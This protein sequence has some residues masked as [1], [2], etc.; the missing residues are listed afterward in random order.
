MAHELTSTDHMVSGSNVT[1]WHGL[2]TV[3]PGQLTAV[4][5]LKA[6]KLDWTVEQESLYDADTQ[7]VPG[8]RLNRRS[9]T[10]E[11]LGVVS[12]TWQPVQN[13]RLLEIAEALAQVD[14]L[15]FKPVIETA[16]SLRAGRIVWAM[17]QVGQR[18]FAGS[19]HKSY[20]LLSNGHD[21]LRALRGTLTDVR[22]V[23]ANTLRCAETTAASLYVSHARGVEARVSA[24]LETLGWANAATRSTFAIYEALACTKLSTDKVHKYFHDLVYDEG[25]EKFTPGKFAIEGQLMN[26]YT[27]GKGNEGKTAFDALNAATDWIDHQRPLRGE[28]E[29]P[30]RRFLFTSFD[31]NGVAFKAKAF[32]KARKLV[33]A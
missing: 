12:D 25:D 9:D 17:V 29:N 26:L 23:C 10:R 3:L 31:G 20:L 33:T 14:D 1:P 21:G 4:E 16:G 6:A 22:V 32:A 2:G 7:E 19:A 24:A 11:V 27:S 28:H 15:D 8:Y 18:E 13:D 30:E 5:A